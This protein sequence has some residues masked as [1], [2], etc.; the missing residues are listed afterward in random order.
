M[1][2]P[3][4][5]WKHIRWLHAKRIETDGQLPFSSLHS[6]LAMAT[7]EQTRPLRA[8][9]RRNRERLLEA[10]V[11]ALEEVGLEVGVAEIARRAGVGP[12]T[13]FRHF[14]TKDHLIL[15]VV[16]RRFARFSAELQDCL[17]DPD[18]WEG[19]VRMLRF[20][21]ELSTSDDGIYE[22]IV[23]QEFARKRM[24]EM[25]DEMLAAVAALLRRA[26]NA[27][28]VRDDITP[29]D[30]PFLFGA[31]GQAIHHR[32]SEVLGMPDLW[33]RYLGVILD[34][35]RPAAATPLHPPAPTLEDFERATALAMER[36][37][38]C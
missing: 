26:Q 17:A 27:G 28:V 12:A 4:Q 34:G 32:K 9:A 30:V 2:D 1:V 10:A 21:S 8:D 37:E 3:F 31:A 25:R 29:E 33:Q 16:E 23:A 20:G 5:P 38:R 19:F 24:L 18:P 14:P 13:L 36:Q 15:A 6:A 22:A 35:L 11:A 7:P